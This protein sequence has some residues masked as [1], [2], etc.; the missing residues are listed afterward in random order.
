MLRLAGNLNLRN[1]PR[2][3]SLIDNPRLGPRKPQ[4]IQPAVVLK[5]RRS[6]WLIA[7]GAS[8]A[9]WNGL[10]LTST[11]IYSQAVSALPNSTAKPMSSLGRL[12]SPRRSGTT[13]P[14]MTT[15]KLFRPE[16]PARRRRHETGQVRDAANRLDSG[17][18]E[19]ANRRKQG[20]TRLRVLDS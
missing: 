6:L 3:V 16:H 13:G 11:Y 12:C 1:S 14:A 10:L 19:P 4:F 17:E 20:P 2:A 7:L 18:P 9:F 8:P 15:F 5:R